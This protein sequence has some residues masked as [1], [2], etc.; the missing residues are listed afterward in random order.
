M[1]TLNEFTTFF[2]NIARNLK[3]IGHTDAEKHFCRME[4]EEV[5][6]GMQSGAHFRLLV[7]ETYEFGFTDKDSDN[8][9]KNRICGLILLD[10][11]K[12]KDDF[13]E[14][15]LLMSGMEADVDEILKMMLKLKG[16]PFNHPVL[17]D[18]D[19]S[20]VNVLPMMNGPDGSCGFRIVFD[21][22]GRF[23]PAVDETKWIST[24]F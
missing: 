5:I 15:A 6:G 21:S 11:P 9:I 17:M 19:I 1:A 10:I 24:N 20:T 3:S 4:F 23:S 2:E 8:I 22:K 16:D 7:M 14:R 18:F 12:N 13:T